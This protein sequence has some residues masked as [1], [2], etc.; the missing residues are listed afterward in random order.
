[1]K[2]TNDIA[3]NFQGFNWIRTWPPRYRCD[4]LPTELWSHTLGW[5]SI[6]WVQEWNDVKYI[7]NN[8]YVNCGCRW[9]W[10]MIIA[11][12][13]FHLQPQFTYELIHIYFTSKPHNT[14]RSHHERDTRDRSSRNSLSWGLNDDVT[15][16]TWPRLFKGWITLSTG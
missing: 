12:L 15:I 2:V 1:M 4:A 10:R 5:R 7:W 13:H 3:V 11:V 6:N 8:S 16:S 14:Q 9:K